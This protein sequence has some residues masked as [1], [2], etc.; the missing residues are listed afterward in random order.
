M[1]GDSGNLQTEVQS[2]NI[3]TTSII[4]M[5]KHEGW[6]LGFLFIIIIRWETYIIKKELIVKKQL[7]MI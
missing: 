6:L 7:L 3:C 4:Y 1:F 2:S 5:K